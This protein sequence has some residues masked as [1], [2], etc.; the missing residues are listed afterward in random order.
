[1]KTCCKTQILSHIYY[2]KRHPF[3]KNYQKSHTFSSNVQ[4]KHH[5]M[6]QFVVLHIPAFS[7]A[8]DITKTQF[9]YHSDTRL[10]SRK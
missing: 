7:N 4:N 1:M 10:T 8:S 2:H 3:Q 6:C 9:R 5:P